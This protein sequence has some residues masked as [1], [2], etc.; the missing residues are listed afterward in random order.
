ME[1]GK[2]DFKGFGSK[3]AASAH[4]R[5]PIDLGSMSRQEARVAIC[6]D[7]LAAIEAEKIVATDGA[8]LDMRW[9]GDIPPE[10]S[11]DLRSC[12]EKENF[13]CEVCETGAPV[14]AVVARDDDL[15][16]EVDHSM[17]IRFVP[18]T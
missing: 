13:I 17:P 6:M 9:S 11:R 14:L 5:R 10:G 7:A 4:L 16:V 2:R 3:Q 12:L 8:Y 1:A 15:E 18:I